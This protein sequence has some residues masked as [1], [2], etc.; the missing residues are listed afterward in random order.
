[1]KKEKKKREKEDDRWKK[2]Y[3][4]FNVR[5]QNVWETFVDVI[6]Q[7]MENRRLLGITLKRDIIFLVNAETIEDIEYERQRKERGRKEKIS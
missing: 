2:K 1:M 4:N 3:Y 7:M 5:N 6:P